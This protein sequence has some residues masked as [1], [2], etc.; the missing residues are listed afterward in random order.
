MDGKTGALYNRFTALKSKK[1][2]LQ[3]WISV[4]GWS[5][6]DPG[7]TRT[8]FSDMTSTAGNRAAFINGLRSFMSTYGFDG[9]DLDWEYPQADDRGG[10]E[11]DT[12]NYVALVKEMKAAFGNTYGISMT[13]PTSYW[14]LQHFDLANIQ[15]NIDWFNLMA[16]D[17]HGV[18]DAQSLFVGP[19][20]APH[21]NISEI[22]L[23]MDLLWRAGVTPDK[24]VL[25]QGWYG[26]SFTLADSSCNTPNGVCKF[27]GPANAGPCSNAAG[28]LDY[29]EIQDVIS[30]NKLSPYWDH[31]AAVKWI[32][33]GKNQW[34]SYDD[35]DTFAQKREFANNRCLGGTMVW[36]IDQKDQSS[37]TNVNGVSSNNQ[38]N[39]QGMAND[40]R[41]GVTCY[42]TDCGGECKK[43]TNGVTQMN[44]QPGQ[45]STNNRC[46]RGSYRTL[47]CDDGTDMGRCRWRGYR[48]A[49]LSCLSGCADGET[50]LVK[51]TN[52]HGKGGDQ[53]CT[54]GLQ[55]YCCAG[56]K[57][58][59]SKA[60]L[61]QKAEDAA[62]AAAEAAAEQLALDVA[63]KAFCRI[64]VPALLAPL[65]L[66]EDL[67]PI[68]GEILDIAEVAATPELINLCVK[69]VEKEGKAEFKVFGKT[70]TLSGFNKPT[71]PA[72]YN[73]FLCPYTVKDNYGHQVED[74]YDQHK[75]YWTDLARDRHGGGCD[76]DE[77]PPAFFWQEPENQHGTVWIRY[78]DSTNQQRAGGQ[79]RNVCP[80]V[81]DKGPK[82]DDMGGDGTITPKDD[83]NRIHT[84]RNGRIETIYVRC[85]V[86][87]SRNTFRM[88]FPGLAPPYA[89]VDNNC[90]PQNPDDPGFALLT[91]DDW[92][93]QNPNFQQY[94]ARYGNNHAKRNLEWFDP[95]D[96][97]LDDG[98]STRKATDEELRDQLGFYR[99]SDPTCSQEL[100]ELGLASI[101]TIGPPRTTPARAAMAAAT[102]T[103]VHDGTHPAVNGALAVQDLPPRDSRS[104]GRVL[105]AS[106]PVQTSSP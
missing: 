66:L 23:G 42:A 73:N 41:A 106:V 69:G 97:V 27:S 78:I 24:V 17:L 94:T 35:D 49:G 46:P 8:A 10:A 19:Y 82:K 105:A 3:T 103:G 86:S 72:Q 34:I 61:K 20:I 104:G 13:L 4:G 96:V 88:N 9:V 60:D 80:R 98:N 51:D 11:A 5:F 7:P 18:W 38:Q 50:E 22:D 87:F 52:S 84:V 74:Y 43:G 47:C 70:R 26:R 63:A 15:P 83:A 68:V 101:A 45:L 77:W 14:Y 91:N 99:C 64:A 37:D 93:A 85:T 1:P 39:A 79:W 58:A 44:G 81:A 30:Q 12:S 6:T 95:E 57:P 90:R 53:T 56:F 21:T 100:E 102:D 40:L 89:V 2:G 16:Y 32:T 55:S 92:Y 59:P 25:G 36:A 76:A 29:Q 71:N 62:K 31:K 65:E 28:I 54:G 33:W 67:I 48:G 75:P